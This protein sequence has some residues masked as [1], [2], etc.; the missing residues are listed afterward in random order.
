[1]SRVGDFLVGS[2]ALADAF[3]L[4]GVILIVANHATC[5]GI[6][7]GRFGAT[8]P[9]ASTACTVASVSYDFRLKLPTT[10]L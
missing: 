4:P 5:D 7:Q 3:D 6:A 10:T 2:E 9:R 8:L 1:M